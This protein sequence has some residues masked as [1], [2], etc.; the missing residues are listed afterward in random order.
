MGNITQSLNSTGQWFVQFSAAMLIQSAVLIAVLLLFNF[1]LRKRVRA[2]FRYWILMLILLK[3]VLPTSLNSPIS[4]GYWFNLTAFW[5]QEQ[6][7][8]EPE[9]SVQ[10]AAA[11]TSQT[12]AQT[13]LQTTP[14]SPVPTTSAASSDTGFTDST[15]ASANDTALAA[16]NPAT[17]GDSI[18]QTAA[19]PKPEPAQKTAPQQ[20]HS[21]EL[22]W[23]GFVFI[24]WAA[25]V[26]ALTLLLIQRMFFV[27]GLIRQSDPASEKMLQNLRRCADQLHLTRMPKLR[28]SAVGASPSVCGLWRHTILI[29]RNLVEKIDSDQ[30]RSILLHELVH[31]Q[32]R[33]LP[34]SFVQTVLQII[35]FYNPLLWIANA[36]IRRVRE[37]A[38]D[39]Q[40]LVAMGDLAKQYPETLLKISKLLW[41][42]PAMSLRLIGVVESK[43][44][45]S[46]RIRHMMNRPFPK[47][48]KLG[49]IGITAILT[50]AAILIPMAKG[51]KYVEDTADTK[52]SEAI[53]KHGNSKFTVTLDNGVTVELLGV[54]ENPSQGKQWWQPDGNLLE[55][56]PYEKSPFTVEGSPQRYEFLYRVS[57]DEDLLT[58]CR[59]I[60]PNWGS[61]GPDRLSEENIKVNYPNPENLYTY[62][63]TG[64]ET[65]EQADVMLLIGSESGWETVTA[66]DSPSEKSNMSIN[67]V[68]ISAPVEKEGE[69]HVDVLASRTRGQAEQ[70]RV[71]AI[72]KEGKL[73]AGPGWMT[74]T[75]LDGTKVRSIR[76]HFDM[77]LSRI[78]SIKYQTQRFT[79]VTFKN[80]SLKPG[81]KTDVEVEG[82]SSETE[83][84]E[85][86]KIKE[87]FFPSGDEEK[88][89]L[90]L[91]TGELVE[92]PEA[93]L[94]EQ[95]WLEIGRLGKGDIMYH[96]NCLFFIRQAS[97]DK[98]VQRM[99][100][101]AEYE[102]ASDLPDEITVTTNEGRSYRVVVEEANDAGC[103]LRWWYLGTAKYTAKV[104]TVG[105]L[106]RLINSAEPGSIVSVPAGVYTRPIKIDKPL[107]LKGA[108]VE[109]CVIEVTSNEPAIFVDRIGEG[110]VVV[111]GVTVKW[112]LA[113]SDAAGARYAAAVVDSTTVFR[114]CRWYP[115]GNF[116]RCP[117]AVQSVGFSNMRIERCRFEGYE[118]TVCFGEGSEGSITDSFV[119]GSG[120]QGISLY[121]GATATVARNVVCDSE[122]HGVRSTGGTLD[123]RDNLIINNANRGLY[124]GN[125]T[126]HGVVENNI[127]IGSGLVGVSG[128]ATSD[129]KIR[130]NLIMD[131]AEVGVGLQTSCRLVL[132][133]NLIMGSPE[134]VVVFLKGSPPG[135][136]AKLKG[137]T[138]WN[139]KVDTKNCEKGAGS[140]DA[141][142]TL[143][144][145]QT[146]DFAVTGKEVLAAGCGLKDPE[147]FEVLWQSWKADSEIG[148]A[149]RT[150][151]T[152]I[153]N[154]VTGQ[155]GS[156]NGI[157]KEEIRLGDAAKERVMLDLGSGEV[158]PVPERNYIPEVG[159][160][161]YLGN[162]LKAVD[163]M[164]EGAVIYESEKLM[165][166]GGA[167]SAVA[168]TFQIKGQS[169]G[170]YL[171]KDLLAKDLPVEIPVSTE[172]GQY[173]LKV[174]GFD[175]DACWL[176]YKAVEGAEAQRSYS[177]QSR[178][179]SDEVGDKFVNVRVGIG[180]VVFNGKEFKHLNEAASEMQ[181]VADRGN[182]I[183]KVTTSN[184]I[185]ASGDYGWWKLNVFEWGRDL[186]GYKDVVF[187]DE[188]LGEESGEG[189]VMD[190]QE[191]EEFRV[192]QRHTKREVVEVG[193]GDGS[194]ADEE[195]V[196]GSDSGDGIEEMLELMGQE[197]QEYSSL[198]EVASWLMVQPGV[199][200]VRFAERSY[201][202]SYPAKRKVSFRLYGVGVDMYFIVPEKGQIRLIG[203]ERTGGT[204]E[205]LSGEQRKAV[206][207]YVGTWEMVEAE[208]KDAPGAAK[209]V[210]GGYGEF[211]LAIPDSDGSFGLARF[212]YKMVD[213]EPVLKGRY[214]DTWDLCFED[215]RIVLA[216]PGMKMVFEKAGKGSAGRKGVEAYLGTW[217]MIEA[218]TE[219][220]KIKSGVK[221]KVEKLDSNETLYQKQDSIKNALE[222]IG[223][224]EDRMNIGFVNKRGQ[225][226]YPEQLVLV[227]KLFKANLD[228]DV[229]MLL[230]ILSDGTK[231]EVNNNKS[232]AYTLLN[233]IKDGTFLP[234]DDE[235]TIKYFAVYR[236]FTDEDYNSL[237]DKVSWPEMPSHIITLFHFSRPGYMITG[238]VLYV[239]KDE[240]GYK[241]VCPTSL[242]EPV[243]SP[244]RKKKNQ[245]PKKYGIVRFK[246][247]DNAY[248]QRNIWKY[249]WDIE[250]ERNVSENNTFQILK[251]TTVISGQAEL[252]PDVAVQK[253]IDESV[254]EKYKYKGLKCR[255]YVGDSEPSF[256]YHKY[257]QKLSGW[258]CGFS[259]ASMSRSQAMFFPGKD[260]INLKTNKQGN[261]VGS[262]L[263]LLS[264]ETSEENIKYEHKIILRKTNSASAPKSAELVDA[265]DLSE[266]MKQLLT[267]RLSDI[268]VNNLTFRSADSNEIRSAQ[269][270]ESPI[271]ERWV[272]HLPDNSQIELVAICRPKKN[273]R[274]FW[275]PGGN[276]IEGEDFWS[277]SRTVAFE[278][279]VI[280]ERPQQSEGE[281]PAPDGKFYS[282]YGWK[283]FD[284]NKPLKVSYATGFGEWQDMG[285]IKEGQDL[286]NYNLVEVGEV[287]KG[288]LKQVRA[289]M[290]WK[291]NPEF[292]IRLV[293]VDNKGKEYPM[294]GSDGFIGNFEAG[295]RM[296]YYE[297]AMGLNK[298]EL[299]HFILQ[300]RPMAWAVFEGFATKPVKE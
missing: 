108:S 93:D 15:K 227:N 79:P 17:P 203:T 204:L 65:A 256:T 50:L 241:L 112:Q 94:P 252:H 49:I 152:Q 132:E 143:R 211:V 134:G 77:P 10:T 296:L 248:T 53:A 5:P 259:I 288:E 169:M 103:H 98:P 81:H 139:N 85:Q 104:E 96:K 300:R 58:N 284:P 247:N 55:Q 266:G 136:N 70:V 153:N 175:K 276:I 282:L 177:S 253:I 39:E 30:L 196:E 110:E 272:Y 179:E 279:A 290:F 206:E 133:K 12:T 262:D 26:I 286:G 142:P 109:D 22:S 106:Q 138:Y 1:L 166:A 78:A 18:V 243:K 113:T 29:P 123:M 86:S 299:S 156:E 27:R 99:E 176:T 149:G 7:T 14:A 198:G 8:V 129:V 261:F 3:L 75:R 157:E 229:N 254:I 210:F 40:T 111:E 174:S 56:R 234:V 126:A 2:V 42:R 180:S 34:A 73:H 191:A 201:L 285:V 147:V 217:E 154:G 151:A 89:M 209:L 171:L 249:E 76:A 181:S 115:L 84:G 208:G 293:A 24:G 33:D 145:P 19:I 80:V 289:K 61:S 60:K 194:G 184:E 62:V 295:Q 82:D 264:F 233:N 218:T 131:S 187:V 199:S 258:S 57:G 83:S 221:I 67:N 74:N 257:G 255:L 130:N 43:K 100:G 141:D 6:T 240:V 260:V 118:Y 91:A 11:P 274:R 28:L 13:Q 246:Q 192:Y 267:R 137:N 148:V 190:L 165:F 236:G 178:A 150:S 102:I 170:V 231:G 287:K 21:A 215:G 212:S 277:Q 159:H 275:D 222:F 125:K 197:T 283:K 173:R 144:S 158:V 90:D 228:K 278:L 127:I 281:N 186:L 291:F 244:S 270:I 265:E 116:K 52:T 72:D 250:L 205:G 16:K 117:V 294:K 183:I 224:P 168:R 63:A 124:L 280:L 41:T 214:G 268:D 163:E 298:E 120:H 237:K 105:V 128:F 207:A 107:T 182:K 202:T 232:M 220:G 200:A 245:D 114:N 172:G 4:P 238:S 273:P 38:V 101:F 97:V 189:E 225:L 35:Y 235:D 44:A 122:Y 160:A 36:A 230:S 162:L 69:T 251:T 155:G 32:R 271:R 164:S 45:L 20:I 193:G 297:A 59:V 46:G 185:K 219:T 263:E 37:Q 269:L 51:E 88:V 242:K 9:D 31:I 54:C 119:K 135:Y 146:G 140:V 47:T 226:A 161:V 223:T 213:G 87:V 188:E 292:G 95:L 48:A 216:G 167:E 23:Q 68:I 64:L 195:E 121:S 239:V 92:F 71:I 25:A 66:M